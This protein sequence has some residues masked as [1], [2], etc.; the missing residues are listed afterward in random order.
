[1]EE[2]IIARAWRLF[3]RDPSELLGFDDAQA[4]NFSGVLVVKVD[5]FDETTDWLPGMAMG[6]VGWKATIAAL[7]DVLVKG[8]K[9]LGVLLGLGLPEDSWDA[10]DELFQG[11]EEACRSLGAYVWGGDTNVSDHLYLSITAVAVAEQLVPRG[12]AKP[13]DVLLVAGSG[14]LSPVAYTIL[15]ESAPL[16]SGAEAAVRRAYRPEP[17]SAG[18]WLSVSRLATASIDDSDGFALSLHYLAEASGVRLEL[19]SLPLSPQLVECA[20]TWGRNPVELALYRGGEEYSF[21]F[22][23]PEDKVDIVLQEAEKHHVRVWRIGKVAQ[24]SGVYL[25][26]Y[27]EVERKGWSFGAWREARPSNKNSRAL[28]RLGESTTKKIS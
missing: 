7:S 13:G 21:I 11:V 6:D 23:V 19:D 17:V 1:M 22:T 16:C 27:G 15:L 10:V 4:V 25:K 24:G 28:R 2:E 3:C 20:E 14:I 12:G 9:P 18:F 5:V 26:H 8:A